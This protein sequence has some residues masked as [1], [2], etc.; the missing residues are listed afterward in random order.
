MPKGQSKI[1][2]WVFYIQTKILIIVILKQ[3][4]IYLEV[5]I[6]NK[7]HDKNQIQICHSHF[8]SGDLQK[9]QRRL[10]G[11]SLSLLYLGINNDIKF[12]EQKLTPM[13]TPFT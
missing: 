2:E 4:E 11:L 3:V 12:S 7:T 1:E 5:K 10:N 6:K 8:P 9:K 13:R